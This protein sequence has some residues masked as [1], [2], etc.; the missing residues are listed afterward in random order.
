MTRGSVRARLGR[1]ARP[2]TT[3]HV[4]APELSWAAGH[5]VASEPASVGRRGLGL[6]D[7]W[8][9]QSPPRQG[10]GVRS[11]SAH[12]SAGARLA[13]EAESR[14]VGYVTMHDCA[15]CSLFWFKA[16]MQ[17][18][19][20]C[21]IPTV[22]DLAQWGLGFQSNREKFYVLEKPYV[23]ICQ[24]GYSNFQLMCSVKIY[25]TEQGSVKRDGPKLPRTRTIQANRR[26]SILM[27]G[28]HPWYVI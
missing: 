10:G 8:Q 25:S 17:G 1:E 20:V 21:R 4:V 12:G 16:C 6:W 5:V 15:P 11:C 19:S 3:G 28:G 24:T 7:T 9:R 22:N 13:R 27:I 23:P 2:G 18:Y 26:R 14:V